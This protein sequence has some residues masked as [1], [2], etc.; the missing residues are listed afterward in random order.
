MD[1]SGSKFKFRTAYSKVLQA[2]SLNELELLMLELRHIHAYMISL[3]YILVPHEH[4]QYMQLYLYTYSKILRDSDILSGSERLPLRDLQTSHPEVL[5]PSGWLHESWQQGKLFERDFGSC[6]R[7]G[8]SG[9]R[10]IYFSIFMIH[11]EDK[12]FYIQISTNIWLFFNN[13]PR[14]VRF[15]HHSVQPAATP[16]LRLGAEAAADRCARSL[17]RKQFDLDLRCWLSGASRKQKRG[18]NAEVFQHQ[19][20]GLQYMHTY[21]HTHIHTYT[22]THIH[23]YTYTHIHTYTYI[24]TYLHTYLHT[25][26]HSIHTQHTQNTQNTQYT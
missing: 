6:S 13:G 7:I 23:I 15:S 20:R 24:H 3:T 8:C 26:I 12:C 18:E 22:H 16:C 9:C 25:Y 1:V 21:I 14:D 10:Y 2:V 17:C 4:I 5:A 11:F 19:L